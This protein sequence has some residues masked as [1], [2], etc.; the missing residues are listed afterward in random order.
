MNL[1]WMMLGPGLIA[2]SLPFVTQVA[3]ENA[4]LRGL[5]GV[6]VV[7][8]VTAPELARYGVDEDWLRDRATRTLRREGVALLTRPDASSLDRQPVLAVQLETTRLPGRQTFAWHLSLTLHQKTVTLGA[9]PD[10]VLGQTWAATGTLGISSG[11]LL[12]GS[13]SETLDEKLAEF[14]KVWGEQRAR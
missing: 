5:P 11:T 2:V 10:T 7:A 3:G 1:A 12:R 6:A 14:A 8:E 9:P 13:V 4:G